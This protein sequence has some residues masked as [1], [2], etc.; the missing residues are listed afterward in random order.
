VTRVRIVERGSAA[1]GSE[2]VVKNVNPDAP[3]H[4]RSMLNLQPRYAGLAGKARFIVIRGEYV[5]RF[6]RLGQKVKRSEQWQAV[7]VRCAQNPTEA[8]EE[9]G[10]VWLLDSSALCADSG[11]E[12]PANVELGNRIRALYAK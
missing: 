12:H 2:F 1:E 11:G 9:T 6:V 5:G 8:D 4:T 10:N 3:H 7:E